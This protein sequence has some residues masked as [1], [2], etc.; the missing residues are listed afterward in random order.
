MRLRV[1]SH[2]YELRQ[3]IFTHSK[4]FIRQPPTKQFV[5]EP[6][7]KRVEHV[8]FA[9]FGNL[10]NPSFPVVSLDIRSADAIRFSRQA[11]HPAKLMQAYLRLG[12][13]RGEHIA[14]VNGIL[15][16]AVEIGTG[17]EADCRESMYHRTIPKHR[18]VKARAIERHQLRTEVRN[19]VHEP[20]YEFFLGPISDVRCPE[21]I[22]LPMPVI[23]VGHQSTD[24]NIMEW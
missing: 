7:P 4:L 15:A 14:K 24:T 22:D 5:A 18:Q 9:I 10:S 1:S 11:H 20:G 23:A 17:R 12:T 2:C 3:V 8:A 13:E 16:V 21:G 19:P 6:D